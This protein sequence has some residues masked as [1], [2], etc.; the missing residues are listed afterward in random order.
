MAQNFTPKTSTIL[1]SITEGTLKY[2]N[3]KESD[4]SLKSFKSIKVQSYVH[5]YSFI[6][7]L[8]SENRKKMYLQSF[9]TKRRNEVR[10]T[11]LVFSKEEISRFH[12]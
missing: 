5:S 9:A 6:H 8:M 12:V 3:S 2:I 11:H 1:Y 10:G 4:G 7:S